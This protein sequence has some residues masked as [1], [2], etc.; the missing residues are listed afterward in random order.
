MWISSQLAD[1]GLKGLLQ[2]VEKILNVL[3]LIPYEIDQA[4]V[5]I[6]KKDA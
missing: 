5:G 3:H 6:D 2:L 1:M 4:Q